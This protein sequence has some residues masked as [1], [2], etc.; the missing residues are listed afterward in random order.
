MPKS[1][2]FP[3]KT[4]SK[5][6]PLTPMAG[7]ETADAFQ[8]MTRQHIAGETRKIAQQ[9]TSRMPAPVTNAPRKKSSKNKKATTDREALKVKD[10]TSSAPLLWATKA[11]PQMKAASTGS[12]F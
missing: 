2:D 11:V 8:D 4:P 6:T 10:S 7:E 3:K 1:N 5:N 9:H 12:T